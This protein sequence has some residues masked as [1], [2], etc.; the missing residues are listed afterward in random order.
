MHISHR[1]WY[2]AEQHLNLAI[3]FYRS[4]SC[5]SKHSNKSRGSPILV[6]FSFRSS[7]VFSLRAAYAIMAYR[8]ESIDVCCEWLAGRVGAAA[9]LDGKR[10]VC[11]LGVIVLT[12]EVP[13]G[14]VGCWGVKRR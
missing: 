7:G 6:F 11:F 3:P 12:S 10:I 13:L 5:P 2:H 14:T 1:S 8:R 4:S 9:A